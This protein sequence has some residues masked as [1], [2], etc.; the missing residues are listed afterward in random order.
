MLNPPESVPESDANHHDGCL[1]FKVETAPVSERKFNS[2]CQLITAN[3]IYVM[4]CQYRTV[5]GIMMSVKI[6]FSVS[7]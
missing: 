3:G 6:I 1:K 5:A 7:R 2:M 4:I